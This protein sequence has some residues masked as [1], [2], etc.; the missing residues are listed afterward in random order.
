MTEPQ[1]FWVY[2]LECR[3]GTY[4]CGQTS[5]LPERILEHM[6]GKGAKYTRGKRMPCKLCYAKDYPTRGEAM[7]RERQIKRM[8][9]K[10]KE[11]LINATKD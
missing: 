9:R 5:R 1:T 11:E 7:K 6:A 3:G 4:Y 10:Q 8:S 2:I